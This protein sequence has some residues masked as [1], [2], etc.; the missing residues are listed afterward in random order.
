MEVRLRNGLFDNVSQW[1]GDYDV[2]ER[3]Q[4]E[5]RPHV[6]LGLG[7]APP[8]PKPAET[9]LLKRLSKKRRDEDDDKDEDDVDDAED[10]RF[11]QLASRHKE[12]TPFKP[13]K[14][15]KRRP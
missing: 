4:P 2:G 8:Q 10:S 5:A 13:K 7:A 9:S 15:K 14:K 6:R 11:A 1:I 12:P 3:K